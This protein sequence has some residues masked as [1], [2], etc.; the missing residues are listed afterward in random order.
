MNWMTYPTF[1]IV[2]D[3]GLIPNIHLPE[4]YKERVRKFY[5][6]GRKEEVEQ[7]KS[8]LEK[9]LRDGE[10]SMGIRLRWDEQKGLTNIGVGIH[11]GL[12]LLDLYGEASFQEHNLGWTN[13]FIAAAI[14]TK[15]VSELLKS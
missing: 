7:Y 9:L 6:Q 15:Y 13:G 14:A 8:E 10:N 2:R 5:D 1:T 3:K 11:G 4:D 12:D